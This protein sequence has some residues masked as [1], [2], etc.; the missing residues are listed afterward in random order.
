MD[1]LRVPLSAA[2]GWLI[3]S[4]RL[5]LFTVLGAALIL[6]GNLLNLKPAPSTKAS[7]PG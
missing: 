2:A 6:T 5:D 3:Y 4:E 7:A 1:F